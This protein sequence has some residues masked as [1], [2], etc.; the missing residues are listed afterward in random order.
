LTV[1]SN[2]RSFLSDRRFGRRTNDLSNHIDDPIDV[3]VSGRYKGLDLNSPVDNQDD[4]DHPVSKHFSVHIS[5]VVYF[6]F[7]FVLFC[8]TGVCLFCLAF[9]ETSSSSIEVCQNGGDQF[10]E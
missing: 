1:G 6:L 2:P 9:S 7:C 8:F 5:I 10:A 4:T 3:D